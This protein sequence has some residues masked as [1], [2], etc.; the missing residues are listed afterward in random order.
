MRSIVSISLAI[1]CD[2]P[3]ADL[4]EN[5]ESVVQLLV[6]DLRP[7]DPGGPRLG[8]LDRHGEAF[9]LTP[10]RSADDVVDV[11]HPAGLLGDRCPLVQGEH[12]PLRDDEQASQLGEPGDHVVGE[13][14]GGPA[15]STRRGGTV[16]ERHHRQGGAARGG[17]D[18][19]VARSPLAAA[20]TRRAAARARGEARSRPG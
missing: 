5:E 2:D 9:A 18:D 6:E 4:V 13:G 17:R 11:Q 16:D 14:V 8:Q 19:A 1:G 7:D 12:G 20:V 3:V 15:A 10:H